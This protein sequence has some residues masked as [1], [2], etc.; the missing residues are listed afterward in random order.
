MTQGRLKLVEMSIKN[1]KLY[2]PSLIDARLTKSMAEEQTK[3]ILKESG[4]E[5]NIFADEIT[6]CDQTKFKYV[7]AMDGQV[8]GW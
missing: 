6:L 1:E 5:G 2:N 4:L 8:S 7:I 3:K